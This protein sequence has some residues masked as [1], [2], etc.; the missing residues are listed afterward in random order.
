MVLLLAYHVRLARAL[1]IRCTNVNPIVLA[2]RRSG[3]VERHRPSLE[4]RS[5]LGHSIKYA[6]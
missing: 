4:V 5:D 3:G 1:D 6:C 2:C